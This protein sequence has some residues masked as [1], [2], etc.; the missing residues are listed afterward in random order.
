LDLPDAAVAAGSTSVLVGG[1]VTGM[2]VLETLVPLVAYNPFDG[3]RLGLTALPNA[4][5]EAAG[6]LITRGSGTGQLTVASGLVG[7]SSLAAD[8][9]SASALATDAVAELVAAILAGTVEGSTTV[10][11]ALRLAL[12]TLGGKADGLATTTVHYRD[13]ADSKNRVTAT[14]DADGNRTAVTLDLT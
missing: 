13:L 10:V 1:T 11:Q 3:V 5:A 14:V 2:V 8:S 9:V 6:G 12:A 7:V 4:A